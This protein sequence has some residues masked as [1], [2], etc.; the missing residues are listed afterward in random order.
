M[1][2]MWLLL[3]FFIFL[4]IVFGWVSIFRVATLSRELKA[5]RRE[6]EALAHTVS[7]GSIFNKPS[8]PSE[9]NVVDKEAPVPSEPPSDPIASEQPVP[10]PE[11]EEPKQY[12]QPEPLLER[13]EEPASYETSM[14]AEE[15]SYS[16][17][18]AGFRS[19]WMVWLGG[20]CVAL[21]GI[22]LVK[23]SIDI[24]LLS[25]AV[26][27][28][29]ALTGGMGLHAVA[30]WLRRRTGRAD[31][32]FAALAG[33]ASIILY[34]ALLAG[35]HLYHLLNPNLVFVLLAVVSLGTTWLAMIYGPI[36]AILGILGAYI[37]PILIGAEDGNVL[38]ALGYALV[39]TV[40]GLVL[41]R[42]VYRGWLF[43][44]LVV[45]AGVWWM[46]SLSNSLANGFRGLYLTALLYVCM[47]I[48]VSDWLLAGKKKY[49]ESW[50]Y[51]G[52]TKEFNIT[53]A[54][55]ALVLTILAV[56]ISIAVEPFSNMT[57][58]VWL[59]MT[60]TVFQVS[61][62]DTNLQF[63]PWL[64]MLPIYAVWF[65]T[66]AYSNGP[67]YPTQLFVIYTI[68]TAV[69]FSAC[70][71]WVSW[72][73]G[74]SNL[75]ISLATLALPLGLGLAYMVVTNH[76]P[77]WYWGAVTLV[78]ALVYVAFSGIRLQKHPQDGL[79]FWLVLSG[80][81]G[82]SLA[83]MMS[84]REAGLTLAL[85]LQIVSLTVL[86]NRFKLIN[87]SV[88]I[89]ILVSVIVIRLTLNP[90]IAHYPE[91]LHWSLWTYGGSALCCYFAAL[92]CGHQ[93]DVK[94]W[95]VAASIH[96]FVLFLGAETR[97]WLYDGQIFTGDYS[98][99]E[100]GINTSL[101]TA[102][103]LSYYYRSAVATNLKK[104]YIYASRILLL[105]AVANYFVSLIIL[106]PLWSNESV[107]ATPVFNMM[108]LTY[109]VPCV[110]A[111]VLY[112]WYDQNYRRFAAYLCGGG[113]IVFLTLQ[114][115]HLIHGGLDINDVTGDAELY[116]YSAVW[117]AT[118]VVLLVIAIQREWRQMYLSGMGL[119]M[120][121]ILKIF[122][123]DMSGLEGLYRVGSFMALGICLLGIAYFHQRIE[124]RAQEAPPD[125]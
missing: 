117:L 79:G 1:D 27:I 84:F 74:Y 109:G 42:Y 81:L 98:F 113:I 51:L 95:L 96:L 86:S 56:P 52:L 10:V 14:E 101:W 8:T 54:A 85:A 21:A 70:A 17:A 39:I 121:V 36:M 33:G 20:I 116:T 45:G 97:Y 7:H 99:T 31:R 66:G 71:G 125:S 43:L 75:Y 87:M 40:S 69:L 53:P 47:A 112:K 30:D 63:A 88:F 115:R 48:P 3:G 111:Y 9:K 35:L 123:V 106:N 73:D 24:G 11:P 120:A 60:L 65:L 114:V 72:R 26:R 82:Y 34:A 44:G 92:Q 6:L 83:V 18:L 94:R 32:S 89:K 80:H 58:W 50:L 93:Q 67:M 108:L 46:I 124:K 59:P 15:A 12:P 2:G 102:L 68:S 91:G 16:H 22:F 105:L 122:T 5:L 104:L 118:A 76:S 37:V 41:M 23:Y 49:S 78:Q 77:N 64:L 100:A 57:F 55:I 107:S 110:L 13:K 29:L 61:R 4:G 62:C 119:L 19:N 103:G 25:P 28:G 38:V 90:A